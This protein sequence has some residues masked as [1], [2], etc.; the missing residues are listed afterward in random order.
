M[1]I[2]LVSASVTAP[3]HTIATTVKDFAGVLQSCLARCTSLKALRLG[4]PHHFL[5]QTVT[6]LFVKSVATALRYE[7][8]PNLT[9]LDICFPCAYS[10]GHLFPLES[11]HLRIPFTKLVRHLR[12]LG[13]YVGAHSCHGSRYW[14]P[15]SLKN[16]PEMCTYGKYL[17]SIVESAINKRLAISGTNMLGLDT[18]S[19]SPFLRLQSPYSCKVHISAGH[20]LSLI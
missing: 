14:D 1:C 12:H 7:T 13:L 19:L 9:E 3:R 20:L 5:F 2:K 6:S 11:S 10:F 16:I 17:F 4:E 8:L 15:I 18:V